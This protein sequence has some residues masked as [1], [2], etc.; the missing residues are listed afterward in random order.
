[1]ERYLE[2]EIIHFGE[3]PLMKW[4]KKSEEFAILGALAMDYLTFKAAF[5]PSERISQLPVSFTV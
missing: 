1:V 4:K 5:A 3:D 2:E